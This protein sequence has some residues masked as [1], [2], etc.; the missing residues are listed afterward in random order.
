MTKAN[1]QDKSNHS[2]KRESGS[3]IG[4][5]LLASGPSLSNWITWFDNFLLCISLLPDF[6][7]EFI[8]WPGNLECIFYFH[9][10]AMLSSHRD[11]F[12]YFLTTLSP[13]HPQARDK[14][15]YWTQCLD[16][17]TVCGMI[18]RQAASITISL[19]LCID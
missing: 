11:A 2:G 17:L 13:S 9:P 8:I 19:T 14:S 12:D 4:T 16:V 10:T 18:Y 3:V 6:H 7:L 5:P 15:F 1:Y